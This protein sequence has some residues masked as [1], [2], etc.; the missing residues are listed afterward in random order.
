MIQS[1]MRS[2]NTLAFLDLGEKEYNPGYDADAYKNLLE[3]KKV[4]LFTVTPK[5]W[6]GQTKAIGIISKQGKTGDTYA[7]PIIA[8]EFATWLLPKFKMLMI[9]FSQFRD[10]L[11]N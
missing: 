8:C 10:E 6:I 5:Q 4:G 7:H 3:K 11:K 1:W 2:D 9:K